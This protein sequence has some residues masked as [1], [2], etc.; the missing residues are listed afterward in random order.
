MPQSGIKFI[1]FT[2]TLH[3]ARMSETILNLA[4]RAVAL[5]QATV[6]KHGGGRTADPTRYFERLGVNPE[7]ANQIFQLYIRSSRRQ[8]EED[9]LEPLCREINSGL[10]YQEKVFLLLLVMD[11]LMD[12][13]D[14]EEP[15]LNL[16][17]L[18]QGIG[19]ESDLVGKFRE[20]LSHSDPEHVGSKDYLILSPVQSPKDERL[21]GRWIESNAPRQ[22]ENGNILHIEGLDSPIMVMFVEPIKSYVVRCMERSGQLYGPESSIRCHFRVLEPGNELSLLGSPVLSYSELKRRFQ[23]LHEKRPLTL[24]ADMVTYHGSSG[25]REINTFSSSEGTGQLIGIVGREGVGKSTLLKLLAGKIKPD[26]GFIHIN[27]YDLWKNKYLLKGTIG[28][29]PEEDLLYEDLTVADNLAFTA[30]L[31]YSSLSRKEINDKVNRILSRLDLLE[32]KHVVVGNILNKHI[33]PGQRRMINIALELLRE[34]QIL[35]VD[36][37]LS[38]L[39][40]ADASKVIRILH[41]YSFSGNLVITT[42]SQSDGATF[43]FFDKIWILDEGGNAVYN[44]PVSTAASYLGRHLNLSFQEMEE[45][46]PSHLLDLLSY[47]LPIQEGNVWKRVREPEEWHRIYLLEQDCKPAP[48]SEK[49]MLPARML[50]I[51]NLEVQLLI[52]SVRNFKCKFSRL[53]NVIRTLV[54]GPAVAL[55][56]GWVFRMKTG[57]EY[58]F[59]ANDNV[60][61]YLFLSTMVALF[62]GL[63]MSA[64]EIVKERNILEKEQYLEFSRFSYINSKILYLFPVIALQTLLYVLTGN[65]ILGIHGMVTVYWLI[66]FSTACSGAVAG[67]CFSAGVKSTHTLYRRVIPFVMILQLVLGGGMITYDKLNLGTGK[68][69]PIVGDLMVTRWGFEA[70]AV[71][72]F[73]ENPYERNIYEVEKKLSQTSYYANE[74]IPA[75]QNILGKALSTGDKDS[76]ALFTSVL[77]NEMKKTS[78]FTE[79]FQ[80]EFL[81]ELDNLDNNQNLAGET[82]GYLTYMA[83]HFREQQTALTEQRN[84]MIDSLNRSLGADGLSKLIN[85]SHNM[86]L[87]GLV[88]RRD[89]IPYILTDDQIIRNT[90]EIFQEPQ[91]NYGRARLFVPF[92]M[93]N[94]QKTD[95]RW[96]NLSI[97]WMFSAF[98]YLLVLFDAPAIFRKAK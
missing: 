15:T 83:I 7:D 42:I 95:T 52:F 25:V 37:A 2:F 27:G 69:T 76:A 4:I 70:L 45:T 66:L 39:G 64:D 58:V 19:L 36:N 31:Y 94:G 38:G 8:D 73:R 90:D 89:N 6:G 48:K 5:L 13:P 16:M 12:Q 72:Q 98:F 78:A 61:L 84:H 10:R 57:G 68:Y 11:C 71:E 28:Y 54:T 80:F 53:N 29:V 41:D 14:L 60:P 62:L 17:Q 34:P 23:R 91:S 33:Q 30:R 46:D 26:S 67:L 74:V 92:K 50:K 3:L 55:M 96:F 51:P 44:G 85:K 24:Q 79:L 22:T 35:L 77:R 86:A 75:M 97:I 81:N 63:V 59:A 88:T 18:V 49:T 82:E 47:K 32:L 1:I 56:I 9:L 40:M 43:R 20:F 21:E 65:L 93:L 87:A